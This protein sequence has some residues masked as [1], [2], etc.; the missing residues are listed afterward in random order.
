MLPQAVQRLVGVVVQKVR[1]KGGAQHRAAVQ[2][3]PRLGAAVARP[4]HGAAR[5]QPP[6]RD[7]HR[8]LERGVRPDGGGKRG[9]GR[10]PG[11]RGG[12]QQPQRPGPPPRGRVPRLRPRQARGA[13]G[14][15]HGRHE[16]ARPRRVL[17]GV[18]PGAR[19]ARA[20][21]QPVRAGHRERQAQH[22]EVA[23]ER[24]A[25]APAAHREG[26]QRRRKG[27]EHQHAG[28]ERVREVQLPHGLRRAEHGRVVQPAVV[29][30]P[31]LHLQLEA[32]A[33]A[34]HDAHLRTV[35]TRRRHGAVHVQGEVAV[36]LGHQQHERA[37]GSIAVVAQLELVDGGPEGRRAARREGEVGVLADERLG[38]RGPVHGEQPAVHEGHGAPEVGI[39]QLED[40]V[41]AVGRRGQV[42]VIMVVRQREQASRQQEDRCRG[43]GR[44]HGRANRHD[45]PSSQRQ[46]YSVRHL[47]RKHPLPAARATA[48]LGLAAALAFGGGTAAWADGAAGGALGG[49]P[50]GG[51]IGGDGGL[52]PGCGGGEAA[53]EAA[54][55][56]WTSRSARSSASSPLSA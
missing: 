41:R 25:V 18:P 39:R 36:H 29:M 27:A 16:H 12:R 7:A 9:Q 26:E 46:G 20:P 10:R 48:S 28:A 34:H 40:A 22:A 55:T 42:F 54:S 17:Q 24:I 32:R 35:A 50:G 15:R 37:L 33:V 21:R 38:R 51:M 44:A 3:E 45:N 31:V 19:N 8:A 1:R 52:A 30:L 5:E 47:T 43:S 14:P 6:A 13:G 56:T 4:R 53:P 11:E 23:H 2:H 49:L